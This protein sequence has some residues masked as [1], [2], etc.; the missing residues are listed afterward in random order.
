M[1][2][3]GGVTPET[4][5][6]KNVI[7]VD[8]DGAGKIPKTKKIPASPSVITTQTKQYQVTSCRSDNEAI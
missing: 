8:V 1:I 4:K 6:T 3:A 2:G 5:Q 7:K